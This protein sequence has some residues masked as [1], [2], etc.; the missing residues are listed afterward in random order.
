VLLLE[1]L[2]TPGAG[3]VLERLAREAADVVLQTE[4]RAAHDRL[5]SQP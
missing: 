2:G 4:A 1:Y 3:Q 5:A